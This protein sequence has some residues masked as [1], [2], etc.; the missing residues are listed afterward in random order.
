M[1]TRSGSVDPGLLLWLLRSEDISADELAE[2][3]EHRSGLL[4]LAGTADMREILASEE[5]R[6]RFALDVYV[7]RLSAEIAAMTAS[8]GG[9]DALVFTGG[10]G[11]HA[12]PVRSRAAGRLGHLGVDID[13]GRNDR[14]DS[15]A[16]ISAPGASVRT[17]VVTAREDLEIAAGT[18][19]VLEKSVP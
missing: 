14:A 12:P 19:K 5:P 1:A 17:L 9:L 18:R 4:G 15:D 13:P 2:T 16:D 7:H 3:L 8:L 11:E 6:A 10:V